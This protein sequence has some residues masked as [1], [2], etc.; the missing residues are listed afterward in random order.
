MAL[1]S[2]I[3]DGDEVKFIPVFG[4]AIVSVQPGKIKA[5]G[6]TTIKGK[7]VCIEGDEKKVEVANC[8]YIMPPFVIPGSGTLKIK[9]LAPD[10]L[11]Q[12]TKSGNKNIILK[13]KFFVAVFEVKSPAKQPPPANT[14]DPLPMHIG[15]GMLIPN[16]TKIKGT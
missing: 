2:I 15:Q 7:K 3:T 5:S 6:K 1:D 12:K 16:N 11:T 10:Q 9:Q 8:S 13:G 14:P 4:S